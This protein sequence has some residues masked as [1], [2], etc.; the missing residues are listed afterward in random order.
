MKSQSSPHYMNRN[1]TQTLRQGLAEYY[2]L[3]PHITPPE[4]Q[5]PEFA[6]ILLAHDVGH[7]IYGC[8]TGM[9]DEL[10]ILPLFWWTSEWT[11]Q[12]YLGMKNSPAVDVMYDDM[13]KEK[14]ARWLYGAVLK[15]LPS[16]IPALVRIW[17]KTRNWKKRLPFLEFEPLLDRSL[18]DIRQEFDVLQFF[19]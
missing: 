5:P 19:R 7:V 10:K 1:S 16:L 11:F 14:G 4:T 3:N 17:F 18:L 9:Y 12:T 2:A 13:I 15:E 8:D 6:K